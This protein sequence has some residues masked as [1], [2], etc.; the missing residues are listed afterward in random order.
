LV[1]MGSWE[2]FAQAGLK[3]GSSG[4]YHHTWPRNVKFLQQKLNLANT[5][6]KMKILVGLFSPVDVC[7]S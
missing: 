5:A 4:L 2:I 1:E 7:G 3:P 6:L